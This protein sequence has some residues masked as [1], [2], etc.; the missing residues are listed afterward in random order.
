MPARS[1]AVII[2]ALVF[3]SPAMAGNDASQ[4]VTPAKAMAASPAIPLTL[5]ALFETSTEVTVLA[6][7]SLVVPAPQEVLIAHRASDGSVA[8]TCVATPEAAA[9]L[10]T[11][12]ANA[13]QQVQPKVEEK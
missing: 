11:R 8:V 12:S 10:M 2:A 4:K 1:I 3:A 9:K 5:A 7:G 6:N 13:Q